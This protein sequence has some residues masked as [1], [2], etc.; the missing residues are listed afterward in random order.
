[1]IL[2]QPSETSCCCIRVI[3]SLDKLSRCIRIEADA[4]PGLINDGVNSGEYWIKYLFLIS[5]KLII[6]GLFEYDLFKRPE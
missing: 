3:S 4:L 2:L 6:S 1:F 5:L